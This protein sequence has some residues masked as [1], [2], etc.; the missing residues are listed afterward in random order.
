[1]FVQNQSVPQCVAYMFNMYT[2][3]YVKCTEIVNLRHWDYVE[4]LWWGAVCLARKQ[5]H[6]VA[7]YEGVRVIK[8]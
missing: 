8:S 4:F 1:M 6:W 3:K 5:T 7:A 2:D